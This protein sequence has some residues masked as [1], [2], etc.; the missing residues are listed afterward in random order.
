MSCT[1]RSGRVDAVSGLGVAQALTPHEEIGAPDSARLTPL[2]AP[3]ITAKRDAMA[4][5]G[6]PLLRTDCR[7]PPGRRPKMAHRSRVR[8]AV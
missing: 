8:A 6:V 1:E 5:A 3:I 4:I 7:M 2:P